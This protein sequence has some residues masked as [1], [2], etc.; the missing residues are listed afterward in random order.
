M[1]WE[2]TE[3]IYS[4]AQQSSVNERTWWMQQNSENDKNN[5]EERRVKIRSMSIKGGS[6]SEGKEW[7][8]Q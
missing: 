8:A 2:E 7:D 3:T 6:R 5:E 4:C 1:I